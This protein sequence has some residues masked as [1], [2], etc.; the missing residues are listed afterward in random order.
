MNL[1]NASDVGG[2]SVG[3][4]TPLSFRVGVT[5]VGVVAVGARLPMTTQRD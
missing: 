5:A 4:F 1:E 2:L 3:P